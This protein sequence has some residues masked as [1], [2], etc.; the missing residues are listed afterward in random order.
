M[1]TVRTPSDTCAPSRPVI[2]HRLAWGFFL[3]WL[4]YSTGVLGWELA[5]DPLLSTYVCRTR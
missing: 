3:V 1:Q 2:K 5:N 4:A